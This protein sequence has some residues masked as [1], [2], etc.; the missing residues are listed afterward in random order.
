MAANPYDVYRRTAVTTAS[1][2]HLQL[3][4][5]DGCI[6]FARQ[7]SQHLA[8]GAYE[9]A[10]YWTGRSQDI[11]AEW[12]SNL[13]ERGGE[14]TKNLARLYEYFYHR[15]AMG[16]ARRETAAFDEVIERL[17]ELRE[18]WAQLA[19]GT[20]ASGG[21]AAPGDVAAA[22]AAVADQRQAPAAAGRV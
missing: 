21:A 9:D 17:G 20:V 7:A 1:P 19:G 16:L 12:L 14:L 15:L 3:M 4:L 22:A 5:Y 6:R 11:L 13:D 2:A 8:E 18:A 10:A